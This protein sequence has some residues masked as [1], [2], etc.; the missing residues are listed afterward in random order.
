M[1][2]TLLFFACTFVSVTPAHAQKEVML[3]NRLGPT[4]SVLYIANADGSGERSLFSRSGFDYNASFS[5]DGKWIVFTSERNGFGQ[6]DIYRVHPDGSGLER[7][8]DNSAVDDQGVL[9][10]DGTKL[11]FVSTRNSALH[12][13]NI[14]I[15]DL[16]TRQARN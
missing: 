15:L 4:Q 11:A 13:T 3:M 5:P 14:W 6:A 7:L 10:P 12:T 9:S 8:T 16:K 2:R 1:R